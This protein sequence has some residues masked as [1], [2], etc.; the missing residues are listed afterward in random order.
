V[1]AAAGSTI[2]NRSAQEQAAWVALL[3]LRH[4]ALPELEKKRETKAIGKA[5]EAKLTFELSEQVLKETRAHQDSLRELLN[6]SQLLLTLQSLH[7]PHGDVFADHRESLSKEPMAKSANAAGTGKPTSA[8]IPS[9]PRSAPL[10][11]SRERE[12]GQ[13]VNSRG[14]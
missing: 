3:Q 6:V 8:R 14:F 2:L 12:F 5:L 4:L 1:W 11:G 10:C 7:L 9:T 13:I